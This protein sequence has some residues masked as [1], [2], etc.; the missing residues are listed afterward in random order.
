MTTGRNPAEAVGVKSAFSTRFRKIRSRQ[1]AVEPLFS[2]QL[3]YALEWMHL[4]HLARSE[5][6]SKWL[7]QQLPVNTLGT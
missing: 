3:Y 7:H 1:I 5:K 4:Q 6:A 2:N